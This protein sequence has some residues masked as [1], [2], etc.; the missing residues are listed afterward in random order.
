[1]LCS[2]ATANLIS[3]WSGFVLFELF[4]VPN[5]LP[6][7]D[8]T[9]LLIAVSLSHGMSA[10][11]AFALHDLHRQLFLL[12]FSWYLNSASSSGGWQAPRG[13]SATA[14]RQTSNKTGP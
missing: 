9:G 13:L 11:S 12:R 2:D 5:L 8:C 4:L 7:V 10:G 14:G 6:L 1:M 3:L